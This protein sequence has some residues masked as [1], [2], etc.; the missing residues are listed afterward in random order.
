M[1]VACI[2]FQALAVDQEVGHPASPAHNEMMNEAVDNPDAMTTLL[3]PMTML[4]A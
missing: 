1:E 2:E 4:L 3:M